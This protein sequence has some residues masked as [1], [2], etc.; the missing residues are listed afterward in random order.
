LLEFRRNFASDAQPFAKVK[1]GMKG[2][3]AADLEP[4][5]RVTISAYR[6]LPSVYCLLAARTQPAPKIKSL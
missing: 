6:L 4:H 3:K 2:L 1:G 5:V